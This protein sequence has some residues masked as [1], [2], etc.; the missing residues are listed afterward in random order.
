MAKK[1]IDKIITPTFRVSFPQVFK[2]KA[3]PG[4]DKEKFSVVMLFKNNEDLSKVK[5]LLKRAIAVKYPD[6]KIPE[7]FV[8]PLKDGNGKDYDGYK[9][10][11][12]ITASSQF[13]PGIVD[14]QKQTLIDPK[15]FYSGCYAIASI[16]AYCWSYMGNTGVSV[17]LQNIMKVNDGEPLAA[18]ET[19][20]AAFE[21]IPLPEGETLNQGDS[22]SV[23][24][25]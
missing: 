20:E 1:E 11:I 9:D 12:Y 7:G 15:Q 3:A 10:T 24:S 5:A 18:G 23:L 2:A 17:G 13:Q 14:E 8:T 6:G 4:S 16:N 25:L 19:A 22:A 21:S